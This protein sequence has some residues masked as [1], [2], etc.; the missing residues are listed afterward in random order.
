MCFHDIQQ[1]LIKREHRIFTRKRIMINMFHKL[2]ILQY[3][4]HKLKNKMMLILLN[5]KNIKNYNIL[6]IQK[7]WRFYEEMKMCSLRDID[8]ILKNN[9][10]K[11]VFILIIASTAIIN[12]THDTLKTW[13]SLFY[14]NNYTTA[15]RK[16][17]WRIY[18][19]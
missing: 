11:Y 12:I 14:N 15:K 18:M 19:K 10:K 9:E 3:N 1:L 6:I 13:K 5:E 4:V 8:F 2:C 7:S 17:N 16:I